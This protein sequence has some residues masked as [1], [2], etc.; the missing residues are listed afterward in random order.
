VLSHQLDA[1]AAETE[2][3]FKVLLAF[4]IGDVEGHD[5]LCARYHTHNTKTLSRECKCT[6]DDADNHEVKCK[7]I[8]AS[9]LT[10]LHE[11]DDKV[12]LQAMCFHNVRN[13]FDKVCF[14]ANEYG[15]H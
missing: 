3:C 10:W 7:Y 14:G 8:R 11:A 2:F 5:V 9:E 6:M 1:S 12:A 15:I 4:V 13:A